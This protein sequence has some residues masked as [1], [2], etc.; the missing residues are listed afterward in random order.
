[1]SAAVQ[2]WMVSSGSAPI[3]TSQKTVTVIIINLNDVQFIS[4]E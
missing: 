2:M 3:Q 4:M 1:M